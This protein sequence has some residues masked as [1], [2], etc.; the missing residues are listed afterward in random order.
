MRAGDE[1]AWK[2]L[3]A[4]GNAALQRASE[5]YSSNA[6]MEECSQIDYLKKAAEAYNG[7]AAL[8][9]PGTHDSEKLLTVARGLVR[10]G[11]AREAIALLRQHDVQNDANLLHFLGDALFA[12]SDYKNA[13][14]M[15]RRWIELGCIGYFLDPD[16]R[17]LWAVQK[18]T[19]R[20]SNL[21]IALRARLD[22][23]EDRMPN[24]DESLKLPT[25]NIPA[26]RST[27]Q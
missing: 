27:A 20:C 3:D 11:S 15:Y 10:S 5:C 9:V 26:V 22:Y 7:M 4:A 23:L 14:R 17:A 19:P 25:V 6:K 24:E 1:D 21:P 16:D 12:M 2:R 18:S 13:G 8:L